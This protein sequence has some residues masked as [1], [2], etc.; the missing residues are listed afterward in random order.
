MHSLALGLFLSLSRIDMNN[1]FTEK[2]NHPI[3]DLMIL[4]FLLTFLLFVFI[5]HGIQFTHFDSLSQLQ[6]QF[7][8]LNNYINVLTQTS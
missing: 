6:I 4:K 7:C 2:K 3:D 8:L 1:F 5:G